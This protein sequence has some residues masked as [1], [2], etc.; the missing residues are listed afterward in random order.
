MKIAHFQLPGG[1]QACFTT[2]A[3]G[4]LST[5][6]GID[7][8]GGALRREQLRK[9]LGLREL[10]ASAQ[11]HGTFVQRLVDGRSDGPTG[12]PAATAASA[13]QHRLRAAAI[14][15]DGHATSARR[16]GVMVLSA[17]C[18]PVALGAE[19][20]VAVMHAGWRG[21]ADGVL[22]QGVQALRELGGGAG[23]VP[24][25]VRQP[26]PAAMRSARRCMP[27]SAACTATAV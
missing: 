20:A 11:V 1:G 23:W 22:E 17:D 15:A 24:R 6:A 13:E 5:A 26:E 3:E 25:S 7:P 2:T 21:L 9:A 4:N 18:L 27:A 19:G 16:C 8:Q 10:H 12:V 14:T